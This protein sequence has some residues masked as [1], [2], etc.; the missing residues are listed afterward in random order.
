MAYGI[1]IVIMAKTK[2]KS[3]RSAGAGRSAR[4]RKSSGRSSSKKEVTKVEHELPGGFW[5][6]TFAVILI[7]IS[8]VFVATW[9]GKGGSVLNEIHKVG[10]DILGWGVFFLPVVLVFLAVK[11]FRA[12][13][14]KLPF[15]V[16]LA[17][18]LM[19]GWVSG[20]SGVFQYG[21]GM[22]NGGMVGDFL[23]KYFINNLMIL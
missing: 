12:Q 11:I 14:N 10:L 13:N 16:W 17:T 19:F 22:T 18:L 15:V 7:L 23:N 5:R 4:S 8:V 1:I 6:Q 9:F 21:K 2:K 3:T 20:A